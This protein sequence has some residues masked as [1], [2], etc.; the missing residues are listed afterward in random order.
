MSGD[1]RHPTEA[2][3][4]FCHLLPETTISAVVDKPERQVSTQGDNGPESSDAAA[5]GDRAIDSGGVFSRVVCGIDGSAMALEA[6]CQAAV[7]AP[8]DA[9]ILLVGAFDKHTEDQLRFAR[10]SLAHARDTLAGIHAVRTRARQG[11][12]SKVVLAELEGERATLLALGLF[13]RGRVES[14]VSGGVGSS[15]VH[16][17]PCSVLV[18]RSP[19]ERDQFP[20]MIVVGL[21]GSPASFAALAAAREL[22]TRLGCQ[23]RAITAAGDRHAHLDA[24]RAHLAN[25]EPVPLHVDERDPVTALSDCEADLLV[26][27]SRGAHGLRALGSVSERVAHQGLSSVLVVRE[28]GADQP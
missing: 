2:T 16:R 8:P 1:F 7:L 26:V 24:V 22:A 28:P 21:D 11:H 12:P 18:G 14:I 23:L 6:A 19:A 15:L 27:G 10:E 9:E 25:G 17:A 5:G 4:P 3:G 13:F 20:R